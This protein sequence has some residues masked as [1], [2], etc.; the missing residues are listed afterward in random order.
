MKGDA[1]VEEESTLL[2]VASQCPTGDKHKLQ[3]RV[4]QEW[5][6]CTLCGLLS[7]L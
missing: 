1:S 6:L 2:P 3:G 7:L 5:A 4:P